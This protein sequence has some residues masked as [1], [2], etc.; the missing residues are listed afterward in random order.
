MGSALAAARLGAERTQAPNQ[1]ELAR[2]HML[3][4]LLVI[5]LAYDVMWLNAVVISALLRHKALGH[6]PGAF[7]C[8]LLACC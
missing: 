4:V 6:V 5:L 8:L 3:A 2:S 7:S 1:S